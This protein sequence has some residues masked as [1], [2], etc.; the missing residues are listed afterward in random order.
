MRGEGRPTSQKRTLHSKLDSKLREERKVT[1]LQ[2]P[3]M[4]VT[5][6]VTQGLFAKFLGESVKS[7]NA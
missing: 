3:L 4:I 2:P 5:Q 6:L 1:A 7:M